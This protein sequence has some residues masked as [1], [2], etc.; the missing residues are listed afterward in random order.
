MGL[1]ARAAGN[2]IIFYAVV[3]KKFSKFE[4]LKCCRIFQQRSQTD[5]VSNQRAVQVLQRIA[6][7][8]ELTV[9]FHEKKEFNF[10]YDTSQTLGTHGV[11]NQYCGSQA[12]EHSERYYPQFKHSPRITSCITR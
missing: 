7:T 6:S 5:F 9:L 1:I 10:S 3:K 8:A 4:L 11:Y 12:I 2:L